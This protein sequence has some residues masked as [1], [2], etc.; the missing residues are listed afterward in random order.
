MYEIRKCVK[1]PLV[2]N[3]LT[4]KCCCGIFTCICWHKLMCWLRALTISCLLLCCRIPPRNNQPV[5]SECFWTPQLRSLF[6]SGPLFPLSMGLWDWLITSFVPE[7]KRGMSTW[8]ILSLAWWRMEGGGGVFFPN[9]LSSP[10]LDA[11]QAL[12]RHVLFLTVT[13]ELIFWKALGRSLGKRDVRA[14]LC[15]KR[16]LACQSGGAFSPS[17]I[18]SAIFFC[19]NGTNCAWRS[20]V[21]LSIFWAWWEAF[22]PDLSDVDCSSSV[23]IVAGEE[24]WDV[25]ACCL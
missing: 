13:N 7:G 21:I 5:I 12:N 20:R 3:V 19:T 25:V 11:P 23:T 4:V 10:F 16:A 15:R 18:V 17:P 22:V 14:F 8:L 2:L 24:T 6:A 9:F 1:T